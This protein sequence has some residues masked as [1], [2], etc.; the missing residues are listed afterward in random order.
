MWLNI[1]GRVA[2]LE[3][4]A[5]SRIFLEAYDFQN[6]VCKE[7]WIMKSRESLKWWQACR[8]GGFE[9]C[10][11]L[12]G[13]WG[14]VYAA[15]LSSG[16]AVHKDCEVSAPLESL[17]GG[18]ALTVFIL[19]HWLQPS[20]SCHRILGLRVHHSLSLQVITGNPLQWPHFRIRGFRSVFIK[21]VFIW[22]NR[23]N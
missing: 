9:W 8:G 12:H 7:F 18:P 13:S 2:L 17:L 21:I 4:L 19:L 1:S 3:V 10:S 16:R 15:A 5:Q 11:T 23:K 6:N 22:Y 14:S 20:V